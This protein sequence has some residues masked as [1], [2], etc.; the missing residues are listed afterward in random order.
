[1]LFDVFGYGDVVERRFAGLAGR[2]PGAAE[3][4][5]DYRFYP[6]VPVDDLLGGHL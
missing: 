4:A 6:E 1:M 3:S 5:A 2:E